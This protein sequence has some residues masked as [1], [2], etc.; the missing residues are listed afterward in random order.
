MP[1]DVT[2]IQVCCYLSPVAVMTCCRYSIPLFCT[3][4]CHFCTISCSR[5]S[6]CFAPASATTPP[7]GVLW[8]YCQRKSLGGWEL[9]RFFTSGHL[10]IFESRLFHKMPEFLCII[11]GEYLSGEPC[12]FR[13]DMIFQF[14]NEDSKQITC[15]S[16]YVNVNSSGICQN[17]G[18]SRSSPQVYPPQT[19][20]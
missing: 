11:Q 14:L 2:R 3:N 9:E 1:E 18:T 5:V 12:G 15:F 17:P 4:F 13:T 19:G 20:D 8:I 7:I 6:C 16:R 10:N